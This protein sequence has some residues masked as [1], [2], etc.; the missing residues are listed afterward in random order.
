MNFLF[1][2][3]LIVSFRESIE[4]TNVKIKANKHIH[5]VIIEKTPEKFSTC[6]NSKTNPPT[7]IGT[8]KR[9]LYSAAFDSSL[10]VKIIAEIVEPE[11]DIPGRTANP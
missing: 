9:K 1:F 8:L 7:M 5:G 10:P 3:S 11:R 6:N 4:I 2:K